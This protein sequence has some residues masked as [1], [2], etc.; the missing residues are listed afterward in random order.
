MTISIETVSKYTRQNTGSHFLDSGGA[1][2]RIYNKPILKN[3]A[4]MD[5]DYGAVISVTHLLAEFAEIHPLHKQ[6][7]KY[8]NRPENVREP[9]FELG[10]S[11]MRERGYTQSCRDNTYNADNDFDQEFVYEIWTPEH[12]GSDDYLYDDDAVVLIYAHTGCDVRGGYASPMIVT[13]PSCEY[14]MP[15]DFQCS[16]HSEQLDESENERLEVHYSHYPLGQLEEMGFKLDETKQESTG[17]DDS[18]W[19]INDDGKS[20]EV[21]ADY[22][23]CY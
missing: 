7:Y 4:S 21:F 13:F 5:G 1:Y 6:F 15:F 22:T 14:T 19:F 12:S 9:W 17:A 8:A 2:G 11:F 23:G 3:L 18:A 20:I 10:D 16:L